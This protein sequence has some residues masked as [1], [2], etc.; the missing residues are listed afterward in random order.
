[1]LFLLLMFTSVAQAQ[2]PFI[3]PEIILYTDR[4]SYQ[5]GEQVIILGVVVDEDFKP[6]PNVEIF[7][8]V[9][10][11][12]NQIIFEADTTTNQTGMFTAALSLNQ[13]AAEGEYLITA[14]DAEGEYSPG[15]RAFIVCNICPSKPQIVVVTTTLPGPTI[16]TTSTTTVQT[17][18]LRTTTVSTTIVTGA[19]TASTSDFLPIVFTAIL[20]ALFI[21]II[22]FSR[23]L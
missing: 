8:T 7:I 1:M 14:S 23:K 9:F 2:V 15:S 18:Q 13:A 11:P 12:D 10:D 6:V 17:T 22:F 3:P 16:T 21:F 5:G 4:Q 20:I 19:A